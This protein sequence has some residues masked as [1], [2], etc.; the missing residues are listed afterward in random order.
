MDEIIERIPK[1]KIFYNEDN[2][3]IVCGDCLEILPLLPDKCVDLLYT[4]PVWPNS[5]P[6]LKG[7]DDPYGLFATAMKNIDRL[8]RGLI[9]HL[10]CTSDPRFLLGVPESMPFFRVCWLRFSFPSKRGRVLIGSDVAYLFGA[11]PKARKGYHLIP[12]ECSL[13][14]SETMIIEIKRREHPTPRKIEHTTWLIDKYSNPDGLILDPFCG[15]TTAEAC[16]E[17]HRK[18]IG[19]EI[20]EKYCEIAVKRL[21]QRMLL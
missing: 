18:F 9:I 4:D 19:I 20:E 5:S 15:G 7:A 17:L 11:P 6:D 12:G 3:V 16:K 21:R 2:Q 1:D 13:K 8:A 10:G 14:N